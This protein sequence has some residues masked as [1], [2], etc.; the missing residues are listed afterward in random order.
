M[1]TGKPGAQAAMTLVE[2]MVAAAILVV[3]VFGAFSFVVSGRTTIEVAGQERTAVQIGADRLDRARAGG[4]DTLVD[5]GNA[6]TVD[7]TTYS[8]TLTVRE[9]RAD[10]GDPGSLYKQL[11]MTVDW[12]TS[13]GRPVVLRTAVSP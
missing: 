7:G 4:Y 8:W 12:S 3:V 11:E 2:V 9:M 13:R 5:D 10:P 6:V 1:R